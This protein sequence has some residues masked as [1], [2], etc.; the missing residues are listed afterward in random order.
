[1][2][3]AA[4]PEF[5][6]LPK[7]TSAESG[8]SV[9]ME[10]AVNGQPLENVQITWYKITNSGQKQLIVK[11]SKYDLSNYDRVLTIS[12][13]EATDAGMFECEGSL[14]AQTVYSNITQRATLTVLVPP[15]VSQVPARLLKDYQETVALPCAAQGSPQPEI[16]WYFNGKELMSSNNTRQVFVF[17]FKIKFSCMYHIDGNN[18]LSIESVDSPDSGVYQCFAVNEAGESATYTWLLVNSATPAIIEAPKNATVIQHEDTSF[19]CKVTGGPQPE[20]FWKKDG[21]N[22]TVGGRIFKT[23]EQL[24]IGSVEKAD[25]GLYSCN[26]VNI[27]GAASANA[28]LNVIIKTQICKP[29]Q[30]M[31]RV[32]STDVILDCGVCKDESVIPLWTWYFYPAADPQKQNVTS[33][34][35][36]V[37][38]Y[39]N[40]SLGIS[41]VLGKHSGKYECL[42]TSAGG[43]DQRI[44]ILSVTDIP[45]KPLVTSVILYDQIPN[46]ILINWTLPYDG[47]SPIIKFVIESRRETS[48]GSSIDIPW[49]TVSSNVN[50]NLRS[51][52]ITNLLPSRLYRFRVIAVNR[53]GPSLPSEAAPVGEAIKMPAQPPSAA[54]LN[55]FC[56]PRQERAIV[57][58]WEP[59]PE[60]S[61]NGDLLGFMIF[62]KVRM[63]ESRMDDTAHML[64]PHSSVASKDGKD[65]RETSIDNLA[66]NKRYRIKIA[67]YNERGPGVNS[68]DFFVSTLQG[69][70]DS[71]PLNVTLV[72]PTSTV[73][74]VEWDPPPSIQLNGVNQ[75]YNIELSQDGDFKTNISVRF[76]EQNPTGRQTYTISNL[77]KYTQ[78]T[79]QIAC[80]TGAGVGPKSPSQ[81]IRTLEDVPG[82]VT[83]LKIDNIS[84]RSLRVNWKPPQELNGVLLG[85][86]VSI[87]E[88]NASL[89]DSFNR[90]S[91]YTSHTFSNLKYETAYVIYVRARTKVGL[92]PAR[93][94]EIVSGVPPEL[95]KP[96]TQLAVTNIEA[97][98]VLLQ[99][100]PG[101]DG[102][103]S[104][105]LWIV[106]AQIDGSNSWSRI[107]NISD[108]TADQITVYSLHP[109][110]SYRLRIIAQN[111]VGNSVP[112]EACN[113][114]Q[115]KQAAPGMPPQDIT[116]RA[117]SSTSI[118]IRWMPVPRSEWNGD[119]LGY[120]IL[121]RRWSKDVDVNT[122]SQ[123]DLDLVR[124]SIW[125]VVELSNGSSIQEY[126]LT[127]LEEWMDY[128]IQMLSYNAV[129]NS[130][131]SPTLSERTDEDVPAQ[132]NVMSTSKSSTTIFVSWSPVP[133]LQQNGNVQ[134][135]KVKY[136]A[137][138][139][140]AEAQFLE[141]D[142]AKSLNAT[143][144]GLRK[145]TQYSIQVLA[146]TRVGDGVLSNV[147]TVRTASDV[148]GPPIIIYFPQVNETSATV[149][150]QSPEEPN[151]VII[152]YKVSY[153]R[154]DEPNSVLTNQTR[155]LPETVFQYT[156]SGLAAETYYVFSVQA[157]TQD[158]WG[159]AATVDVYTI[160]NRE[161]PD[162]PVNLRID[163]SEVLARSVSIMWAPGNDNF[164]P[165]RNFTVQYRKQG[166]SWQ[167]VEGTI[168]PN[169]TS[170]T[171][172]GLQPN[173]V[174]SFRVAAVNDIGM[175][176]FSAASQDI[177][178]KQDKPDGSPQN[179]KIVAVTRTSIK[180][181]WDQLH[182]SLWNSDFL[183]GYYVRYKQDNDENIPWQYLY[184]DS[185]DLIVPD[186]MP[187]QKYTCNVLAYNDHGGGPWSQGA[188]AYLEIGTEAF[189]ESTVSYG[190][191][192]ATLQELTMGERYEIQVL[193]A[194]EAGRGPPSILQVFLVG[195]VAPFDP[196]SD[197]KV[198]NKSS[199]ELEITWKPPPDDS[200][201]GKLTGYNIHYWQSAS[202][203]C[204]PSATT[205]YYVRETSIVLR[206]L[207]PYTIYCST[208]QALNI[209]GEGP[210]SKPIPMQTS[211]D[212]PSAPMNVRFL[213]ITLR[214]MTIVW[215]APRT[216]NGNITHYQLQYFTSVDN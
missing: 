103:T 91:N 71:P 133:I 25:S 171:V 200:T 38:I 58:K 202:S 90:T 134:G 132:G 87:Q 61:W 131:A 76:D 80:K 137:L 142:G 8:Q 188:S 194:N 203:K 157:R 129:G 97:R 60:T 177:R 15:V 148:P 147:I 56:D 75:G 210:Q 199:T 40:G 22:V 208:V 82:P 31:S 211:E 3:T 36:G 144:T 55:L 182:E 51:A 110:T 127:K 123:A 161:R 29:P 102:K 154:R 167:T 20:V 65:V 106:E 213:N 69:R 156:V 166:D 33:G 99:F 126:Y 57:V 183:H 50:A 187:G 179:V 150:W 45:S 125:T 120:K 86:E 32:L 70:P 63:K 14:T 207:K 122:T 83:E 116:P 68:S 159:A 53:V 43:S 192:T 77:S 216:P 149:V 124:Q 119:F 130:S 41:G 4:P 6:V 34:V 145:F 201:N 114:F 152:N 153:K 12:T 172:K 176:D 170:Y 18:T 17:F 115:T 198:T 37:Q 27:R 195:D 174:Y 64:C 109:Y 160:S 35:D 215:D 66:Y 121:Y 105:T 7:N 128:Q 108:P 104:I 96:P 11:N 44:A 67:A 19:T 178:T 46:S 78:Y 209:A 84:D 89:I 193:T 196:P 138:R 112:S 26:A 175:S 1:Q 162:P 184:A 93:T 59:P 189:R 2:N 28:S 111:I 190:Q 94:T 98:S 139:T 72:S 92:G 169:M 135:Y 168:K 73:I 180:I 54:P 16:N 81:T 95:P 107:Y 48:S 30:N 185:I 155:D 181:T 88:K 85:Y 39:A 146:S 214:E 52:V 100:V 165:I 101:Y 141:V 118:R 49:E 117:N 212:L 42:V 151:G 47:D 79:I 140:G 136:I 113:L 24:L 10:C 74:R 206:N 21:V 164:G 9:K 143:L 62:Y 186:L 173:T 5:V 197:V 204:E 191:F 13:V 158:G 23:Q 205:L 163:T